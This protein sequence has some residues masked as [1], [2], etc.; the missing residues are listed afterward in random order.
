MG[1]SVWIIYRHRATSHKEKF[2]PN[3]YRFVVVLKRKCIIIFFSHGVGC[4][5]H[6]SQEDLSLHSMNP[7]HFLDQ[8]GTRDETWVYN[9]EPEPKSDTSNWTDRPGEQP[10][11]KLLQKF[12]CKIFEKRP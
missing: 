9:D 2:G 5:L 8:I 10:A 3:L 11:K 12:W 4:K 1:F 6:T 7:N